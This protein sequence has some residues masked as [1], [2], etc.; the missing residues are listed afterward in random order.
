MRLTVEQVTEMAPD[1]AS[2]A[3]GKK[4][5]AL[6]NWEGLG[7]SSEALWGKCRG[8]ALYQVKVDLSN[9]GYH[10]SCPSRKF[11]CKHSLGLMLVSASSPDAIAEEPLPD[12]VEEWLSRRREKAEKKAEKEEAAAKKPV[13]E[14]AQQK[15]AEQ[16][17][18]RIEDGL[19]RLDLWMKDLVR[20]GL[21][22]VESRPESFWEEQAKR[23]VDAQAPGLASRVAR[24][25]AIPRSTRDWPQRLLAELG[26]VKLLL[27]AYGRLPELDA[28]LQS[29]VRQA[30]GWNVTQGDLETDGEKVEDRWVI[31]GQWVD[32]EERL[33][34]E[35]SWLIGRETARVALVLQFAP[36]GQPFPESIVAGTEQRGTLVLYPGVLRRRG[37]FLARD[38]QI[39]GITGPLPGYDSIDAFLA[40]TAAEAARQ[41]WSLTRG[42][43]LRGVTLVPHPTDPWIARDEQGAGLPLSGRNHWRM[44]ALSGGRPFDLT[45]GWNGRQ[46][47][48]LGMVLDHTFRVP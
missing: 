11:P 30:I 9:M 22:T 45:G 7:K 37:K 8:S 28:A 10:C 4:L 18:S 3:A 31:I 1:A 43:V 15:R 23:L 2:A 19:A 12:W 34:S 6:K 44:L 16:R 42:A 32:D 41:P 39:D 25:A 47:R 20:T 38:P 13:D 40:E 29:D 36:Q 46:L 26:R 48:P 5:M 33:R 21:A 24:L 14:V 35:R 17:E 27:H